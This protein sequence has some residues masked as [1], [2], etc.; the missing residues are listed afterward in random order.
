[1]AGLYASY[2]LD[3]PT[4]A[5]I[6]CALGL[7]LVLAILTDWDGDPEPSASLGGVKVAAPTVAASTD[8]GLVSLHGRF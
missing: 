6:V 1:M 7:A 4:G 8:Q 2:A 5:A 3:L